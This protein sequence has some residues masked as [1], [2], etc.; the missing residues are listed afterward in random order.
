MMKVS[1][2]VMSYLTF[3]LVTCVLLSCSKEDTEIPGDN[4]TAKRVTVKI[5]TLQS[6]AQEGHIPTGTYTTIE[7]AVV[8]FYNNA[9][10]Q[11]FSHELSDAE[12]ATL[13]A[14]ATAGTVTINGIPASASKVD[15]IANYKACGQGTSYTGVN[16]STSIDVAK[17]H[18][19]TGVAKVI[20]YGTGA[21]STTDSGGNTFPASVTIS[22]AASRLEVSGIGTKKAGGT[23][24]KGEIKSYKL[25][26]VFVPNHYP[27]GTIEEA[28]GNPATGNGTLVQPTSAANY[29]ASFPLTTGT[30]LLNDYND[31]ELTITGAVFGYNVFPANGVANLPN[32]VIAVSDV[33]Y[34]SD[35]TGSLATLDGGNVKY[36]TI[37]E[38]YTDAQKQNF[39]TQFKNANVYGIEALL[40]GLEDLGDTPYTKAKNVAVTINITPWT[41]Q[42]IYPKI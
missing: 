1:L 38:F 15:I 11:V 2:K 41:Y 39:L 24:A 36:I 3:M 17:L 12:I 35:D 31:T 4:T 21:I 16:K 22:P 14:A 25:R 18:P 40:F 9:N 26:G 10:G 23:P 5:A 27:T 42:Q 29:T 30:G 33:V 20:M 8:L 32:V 7:D 6:K 28:T 19:A 13:T 37:T 34:V